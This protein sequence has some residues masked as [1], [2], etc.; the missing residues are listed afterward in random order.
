MI[1]IYDIRLR[2]V[3]YFALYIY[4][5]L[6]VGANNIDTAWNLYK[7]FFLIC[8]ESILMIDIELKNYAS[9]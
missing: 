8:A 3:Y 6:R 5:A 1:F 4:F 2:A 7:C 9:Y